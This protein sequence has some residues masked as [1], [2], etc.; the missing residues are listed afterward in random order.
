MTRIV[1]RSYENYADAETAVVRLEAAGLPSEDIT[2]LS[3]SPDKV[4]AAA[5][6]LI[7]AM[8]GA[9]IGDDEAHFLAETVRRGG[10]VVSVRT[11]DS[12]VHAVEKIMDGAGP[13]DAAQR[14]SEYEREG[15]TN[16]DERAEPYRRPAWSEVS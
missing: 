1:T 2:I 8:T 9:G 5:G 6:S 15:W 16:F 14:R 10:A 7:G 3:N 13:I 4:A 11:S 12:H